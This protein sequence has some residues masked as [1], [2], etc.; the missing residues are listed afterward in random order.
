MLIIDKDMP[1][2]CYECPCYDNEWAT[3]NLLNSKYVFG[4]Y[5]KRDES[6][7]LIEVKTIEHNGTRFWQTVQNNGV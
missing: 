6:C 1:K 5:E 4:K 7:P 3:C 2:C